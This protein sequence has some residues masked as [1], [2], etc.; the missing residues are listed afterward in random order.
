MIAHALVLYLINALWRVP[1]VALAAGLLASGVRSSAAA[2]ARVWFAAIVLAVILP[3]LPTPR[4]PLAPEPPP[5]AGAVT[6][7]LVSPMPTLTTPAPPRPP[8]EFRLSPQAE[9]AIALAFIATFA[10]GLV[11]LALGVSKAVRLAARAAPVILASE[12]TAPLRQLARMRGVSAPRIRVSE[13]VALPAVVG[14]FRPVILTPTGFEDLPRAEQR[15][16]LLHEWAHVQRGDYG[17]N[18]VTEALAGPIAWHPA[19]WI[20]KAR[21]RSM[22]ELACD[23]WAQRSMQPGES[24]ARCLLSLARGAGAS[25]IRPAGLA[26]HI[27]GTSPLEERMTHL[28]KSTPASA[29]PLRRLAAIGACAAVLAPAV[30]LRVTAA[31]ADP[32]QV[33]AL[34]RIGEASPAPA[35][36]PAP[37][38]PQVTRPEPVPPARTF[39]IARAEAPPAPAPPVPPAPPSPDSEAAPPPPPPAPMVDREEIRRTVREALRQSDAARNIVQSQQVQAEIQRAL[40]EARQAQAQWT[41]EAGAQLREAVR[42]AVR[43]Q[44]RQAMEQ[45]RAE[46][47]AQGLNA[48]PEPPPPAARP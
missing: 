9:A 3:A 47:A 22:R 37:P 39:R 20:M 34:L 6:P 38:A 17:L 8:G 25:P 7:G 14:V 30:L 16:A 48:P 29:S 35:A 28:L 18:L 19:T 36:P 23:A 42:E 41:Q 10:L 45:M 40:A 13:E 21:L 33:P 46:M 1:L 15:A 44:V 5:P 11:R 12:V 43:Q 2:R 24:Y 32:I 26:L 31:R 4:L 27:I